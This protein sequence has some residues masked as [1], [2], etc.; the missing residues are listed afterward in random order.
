MRK[1]LQEKGIYIIG[2]GSDSDAGYNQQTNE[3]VA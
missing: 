1:K 2:D 3:T